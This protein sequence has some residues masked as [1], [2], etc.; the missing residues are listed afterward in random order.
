MD[1]QMSKTFEGQDGQVGFVSAWNSTNKEV[2]SGEQ[3]IISIEEGKRINYELRFFE[4]FESTEN[5]YMIAESIDSNQTKVNL[6]FRRPH[7]ISHKSYVGFY[8]F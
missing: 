1:P 8:G 4:P 6:G 7:E 5:A 2:G 3:E